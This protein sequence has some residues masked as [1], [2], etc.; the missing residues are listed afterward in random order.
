[1][2]LAPVVM[3][4]AP[5]LAV[6]TEGIRRTAGDDRGFARLIEEEEFG[7]SPDVG[8]VEGDEDGDVADETDALV[9]CAGAEIAPLALEEVLDELVIADFLCELA[10]RGAD[11]GA[12]AQAKILAPLQPCRSTEM[13][14]E[15]AEQREI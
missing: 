10:A 13:T 14:L 3:R 7:V 2:V 1:M 12:K 11:G 4:M 15:R 8:G 9:G 6:A 5:E